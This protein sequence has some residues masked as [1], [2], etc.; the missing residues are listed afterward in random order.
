MEAIFIEKPHAQ[1]VSIV[2]ILIG[3]ATYSKIQ[4]MFPIAS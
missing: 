3:I 4:L 2:K 1:L